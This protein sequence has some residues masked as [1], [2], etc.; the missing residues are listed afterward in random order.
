VIAVLAVIATN[1]IDFQTDGLR[2][3]IL[4]AN[5]S[6]SWSHRL[7]AVLLGSA[8]VV[9]LIGARRRPDRR[10]AWLALAGIL[11]FFFLDEVSSLHRSI[12]GLNAG[13]LLYLPILVLAVGCIWR[14]TSD[15]DTV[16]G[17]GAS[18]ALLCG[19]YLLHLFA[20]YNER[21]VYL[22]GEYQARVGLKEGTEL[23]GLLLALSALWALAQARP[24][25]ITGPLGVSRR[26]RRTRRAR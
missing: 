17:L 6:A 26:L 3:V 7:D 8:A 11:A 15:V 2:S 5:S 21:A 14:L 4:N 12:D 23:A 10:L 13:K 16:P 22:T 24:S 18:L 20:L 1:L 9:G 25:N 19:A